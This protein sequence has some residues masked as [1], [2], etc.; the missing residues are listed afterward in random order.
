M[1]TKNVPEN[2]IVAGIPAKVIGFRKTD[3]LQ[4]NCKSPELFL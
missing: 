4:Y 2:A 3:S 1:V